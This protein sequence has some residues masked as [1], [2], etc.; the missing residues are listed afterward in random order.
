MCH[1]NTVLVALVGD[2]KIKQR[3][4]RSAKSKTVVNCRCFDYVHR[5]PTEIAHKVLEL[6]REYSMSDKEVTIQKSQLHFHL[7]N[8]M[9]YF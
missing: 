2:K 4:K 7:A 8:K 3:F 5:S 1:I 9:W 6:T